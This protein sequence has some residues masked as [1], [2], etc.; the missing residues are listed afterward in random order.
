MSGP[1]IIASDGALFDFFGVSVALSAAYVLVGAPSV[2]VTEYDQGAA[3]GY[4]IPPKIAKNIADEY[5]I[6]AT[7]LVGLTGGGGGWIIL[8]GTGPIPIDPEPFRTW[9]SLP[10]SKRD[11]LA[12]REAE[13][14]S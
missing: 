3:Y 11:L 5:A 12:G 13:P 9:R 1:K 2:T 14:V 7:I 8:P 4:P 6:F 10:V